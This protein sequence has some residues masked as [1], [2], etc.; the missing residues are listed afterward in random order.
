MKKYLWGILGISFL[1]GMLIF[2]FAVGGKY[3]SYIENDAY[4]KNIPDLLKNHFP[5]NVDYYKNTKYEISYSD[6]KIKKVRAIKLSSYYTD[7]NLIKELKENLNK[8]S[9]II[10]KG[11]DKNL[12]EIGSDTKRISC[13]T[14]F[15]LIPQFY[16]KNNNKSGLNDDFD[17]YILDSKKVNQLSQDIIDSE[18]IDLND[19]YSKGIAINEK[20]R[21]VI[22]WFL[23][24]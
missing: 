16:Y 3:A 19:G 24:W 20:E 2:Y 13:D 4:L 6:W 1:L 12:I 8:E 15:H 17:I 7:K 10:Y 5:D 9:I 14:C 18:K 22:F 21:T 11:T 23:V